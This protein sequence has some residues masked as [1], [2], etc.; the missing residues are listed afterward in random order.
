MGGDAVREEDPVTTII[1]RKVKMGREA[2]YELW[3][4]GIVA[5]AH[6]S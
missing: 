2:E 3:L 5:A 1:S 4:T 6:A